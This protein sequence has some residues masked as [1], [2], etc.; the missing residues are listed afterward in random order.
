MP[1]LNKDISMP[2]IQQQD[3]S[4]QS[5]IMLRNPSILLNQNRPESKANNNN[6]N[7]NNNNKQDPYSIKR[8][9]SKQ[10][11]NRNPSVNVN[12]LQEKRNVDNLRVIQNPPIGVVRARSP[13]QNLRP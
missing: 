8:P 10:V 12:V 2:T 13:E 6:N 11:N 9:E 3:L 4:K 7:N 5:P 1:I